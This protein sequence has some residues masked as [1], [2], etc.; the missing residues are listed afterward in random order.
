MGF[1]VVR[2]HT[3]INFNVP[4]LYN[5]P[6]FNLVKIYG[7]MPLA[8]Y[9]SINQIWACAYLL[10]ILICSIHKVFP[11]FDGKIFEAKFLKLLYLS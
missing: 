4:L 1:K 10:A 8:G 2:E 3:V 5:L 11:I 7:A 9:H 6:F